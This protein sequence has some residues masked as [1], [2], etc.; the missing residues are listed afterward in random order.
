[1]DATKK[2]LQG[3]RVDGLYSKLEIELG[4]QCT[5]FSGCDRDFRAGSQLP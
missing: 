4:S 2:A 5:Q 3:K 1:M